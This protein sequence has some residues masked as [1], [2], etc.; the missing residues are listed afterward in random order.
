LG[1]HGIVVRILS[2]LNKQD[3]LTQN[4]LAGFM[5]VEPSMITRLVKEMEKTHSWVRRERDS[6]DNRLVRVYLT[7]TGKVQAE[8]L[9]RRAHEIE[10]TV[11]RS[12]SQA[13]VIELKR[14]LTV[15]EETARA[16]LEEVKEA[17]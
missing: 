8:L 11:T 9:P 4:H 1:V 5:R 14:V 6:E 13:E 10:K 15:L 7:E 16:E 3:G 12:L 2:L 17:D